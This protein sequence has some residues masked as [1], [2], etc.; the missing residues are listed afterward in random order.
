MRAQDDGTGHRQATVVQAKE[1]ACLLLSPSTYHLAGVALPI[2]MAESEDCKGD[3]NTAYKPT[4]AS[5]CP[6]FNN[7]VSQKALFT[8]KQKGV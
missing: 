5:K 2:T 6:F 7:K 4:C 3:N 8:E 1:I